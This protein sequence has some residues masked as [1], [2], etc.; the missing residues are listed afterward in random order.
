VEVEVH[1]PADIKVPSKSTPAA[2]VDETHIPE[3]TVL[4]KTVAPVQV[5]VEYPSA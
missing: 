4:S 1:V 2:P 3:G 5:A